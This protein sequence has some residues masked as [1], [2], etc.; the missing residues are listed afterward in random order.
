[1]PQEC[2]QKTLAWLMKWH[3]RI[4]TCTGPMPVPATEDF[5]AQAEKILPRLPY[6]GG[7]ENPMTQELLNAAAWLAVWLL[8]KD[9]NSLAELENL[10]VQA[11]HAG[12]GHLNKEQLAAARANWFSSRRLAE[13]ARLAERSQLRRHPGDW[14]FSLTVKEPGCFAITYTECG[15]SKFLSQQG[16]P[17]LAPLFCRGDYRTSHLLGLGLCRTKTIACGA[18]CCDFQYKQVVC[19]S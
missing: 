6:I 10:M 16:E 12:T 2:D 8:S 15:I 3:A 13:L 7:D 18:V 11:F 17:E 5:A 4:S 19:T 1:M 14:V 9:K